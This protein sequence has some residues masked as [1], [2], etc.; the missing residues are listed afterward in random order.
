MTENERREFLK[1]ATGAVLG[2]AVGMGVV[3]CGTSGPTEIRNPTRAELV[4]RLEKLAASKPPRNL[5]PGAM[6]YVVG[7]TELKEMPCPECGETMI[8]G[9]KDEILREYTVPL[10]RIQNQGLYAKLIIPEYCP[11]CGFGLKEDNFQLEIKYPDQPA[12]FRVEL[13]GGAYDLEIMALF[14]QGK[15]RYTTSADFE[16]P[17]KDEVD[18]LKELFGIANE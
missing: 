12:S 10:T 3:G 15:D 14:L 18:R 13:T 1:A 4:E 8:V 7:L 17:L 6:C 2:G 9:E 5:N 16:I 11:K